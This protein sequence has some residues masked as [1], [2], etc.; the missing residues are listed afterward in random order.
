MEHRQLQGT[1]AQ[2]LEWQSSRVRRYLIHR[3][4]RDP[5][6]GSAGD[7]CMCS[8]PRN[9][10]VPSKFGT[11]CV[12]THE[13]QCRLGKQEGAESQQ[14]LKCALQW[15]EGGRKGGENIVQALER[16]VGGADVSPSTPKKKKKRKN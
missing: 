6:T 14:N 8:G 12:R 15:K 3:V 4:F 13:P 10:T 9:Q 7:S 5:H 2:G 11:P 16:E 1:H